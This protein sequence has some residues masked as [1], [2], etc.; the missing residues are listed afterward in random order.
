MN[1]VVILLN[2]VPI[3]YYNHSDI[4]SISKEKSVYEKQSCLFCR[5]HK[6]QFP[7]RDAVHGLYM[8]FEILYVFEN[9][10]L[11]LIR[12]VIILYLSLQIFSFKVI[13]FN[14]IYYLRRAAKRAYPLFVALR[15]VSNIEQALSLTIDEGE[16]RSEGSDLR[17]LF[18]ENS[19]QRKGD[20]TS[21]AWGHLTIAIESL[22][23]ISGLDPA[24]SS[25]LRGNVYNASIDESSQLRPLGDLIL[26]YQLDILP[27]LLSAILPLDVFRRAA[28]EVVCP[29]LFRD[30]IS[31]SAPSTTNYSSESPNF[32]L[33]IRPLNSICP[34]F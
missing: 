1:E 20:A 32:C 13:P 12:Q 17:G 33:Y 25:V 16:N 18:F 5:T 6:P 30:N 11:R 27:F 26:N 28:A 15:F 14:V 3:L 22:Y 10:P 7:K 2:L 9:K 19:Q 24:I 34:G 29:V 4:A 23:E 21:V 8:A 31:T